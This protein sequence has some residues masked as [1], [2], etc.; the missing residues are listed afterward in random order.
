M[1]NMDTREKIIKAASDLFLK[2]GLRSVTIDDICNDL[3]I[4]KKTFY[5][6]FKQ[7]EELI[8]SLLD[9]MYKK[10][11]SEKKKL[12]SE[13]DAID[14]MLRAL[15]VFKIDSMFEKHVNFFYDLY[16][17]YPGV[18]QKHDEMVEGH[19]LQHIQDELHLGIQQG[20]FREDM[21]VI[22]T[23]VLMNL[24]FAKI[25]QELRKVKGWSVAHAVNFVADAFLRL[26]AS[27]KG[28][29]YYQTKKGIIDNKII[30]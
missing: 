17:Y 6:H 3:H 2:Y 27:E 8:E 12:N 10:K 5:A 29:N 16:K 18:A 25:F 28:W 11:K 23:S 4:S 30:E 20:L 21:D 14:D 15:N 24:K 1:L 22:A 7:K 26:V 13:S 9:E 19:V